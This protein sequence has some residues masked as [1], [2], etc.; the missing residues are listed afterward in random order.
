MRD[1]NNDNGDKSK[2]NKKTQQGA[3]MLLPGY[4]ISD[5]DNNMGYTG[6]NFLKLGLLGSD[7]DDS[8]SENGPRSWIQ[9]DDSS[10]SLFDYSTTALF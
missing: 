3:A 6:Y 2:D 8:S 10:A 5:L 4:N 1:R 9:N 7:T